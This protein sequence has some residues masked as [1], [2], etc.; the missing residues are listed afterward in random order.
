MSNKFHSRQRNLPEKVFP[1][2]PGDNYFVDVALERKVSTSGETVSSVGITLAT[3]PVPERRY[4]ADVCYV[5][6]DSVGVK[7]IFGQQ[8]LI[9]GLLRSAIV[10]KMSRRGVS[11]LLSSVDEISNPSYAEIAERERFTPISVQEPE[12]EPEQVITLAANLAISAMSG[13]ETS[14]DFLQ[15]SPFAMAVLAK[16]AHQAPIDPVVRVDLHSEVFLGLLESL[17]RI[18]GLE[19]DLWETTT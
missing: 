7:I 2:R 3:A 12:S 14:M 15:M 10:I 8:K 9:Q 18:P 11:Q 19:K 4:V 16:G 5:K 13:E 1:K 6:H 17:R